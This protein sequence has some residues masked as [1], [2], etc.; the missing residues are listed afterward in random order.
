MLKDLGFSGCCYQGAKSL[1][2]PSESSKTANLPVDFSAA[3][4]LLRYECAMQFWKHKPLL[5]QTTHG[6]IVCFCYKN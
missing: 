6:L 5:E 4:N 1:L 2:A 3:S